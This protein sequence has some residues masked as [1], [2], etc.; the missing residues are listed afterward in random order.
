MKAIKAIPYIIIVIVM[1]LWS[2]P[3]VAQTDTVRNADPLAKRMVEKYFRYSGN[4]NTFGELYSTTAANK[5][6]PSST[7]R[8]MLNVTFTFWK[9]QVPIEL[10]VSTEEVSYR[11]SFNRLGFNPQWRFIRFRIGD[12]GGR[13]SDYTVN[14]ISIR[15][16]GVEIEPSWMRLFF[17]YGITQR[18]VDN[19]LAQNYAYERKLIA[20]KLGFGNKQNIYLDINVMKAVDDENSIQITPDSARINPMENLAASID[21]QLALFK[22]RFR[23]N[24]EVAASV[25]SL[26]KLAPK[27]DSSE[28]PSWARDI[29]P[30]RL[31]TRLD[32]AYRT[33]LQVSTKPFSLMTGYERIGAGYTSLGL[34]YSNND[35]V[36]YNGNA[37]LWIIP[38][39]WSIRGSFNY[40][41]DNLENTKVKT[42]K[43]QMINVST[44]VKPVRALTVN[45]G[46]NKNTLKNETN[47]DSLIYWENNLEKKRLLFDTFNDRY[48]ISGTYSYQLMGY[49]FS[50]MLSYSLQKS[51]KKNEEE[52]KNPFDAGI[53][54]IGQNV[55]FSTALSAGINATFSNNKVDTVSIKTNTFGFN[56]SYNP[57]KKMNNTL[58]VSMQKTGE[59]KAINYTLTMR[60]RL[61]SRSSLSM[62]LYRIEFID[63]ANPAR[64]Y[65]ENRGTLTLS[66]NF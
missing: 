10:V 4:F 17:Y 29:F 22:R 25:I 16:G 26:N 36:R 24:G 52:S 11:Q 43:H 12:F 46:Y 65:K 15:G 21:G 63:P 62:N 66:Y 58:A 57:F 6:R 49:N 37:N 53:V 55:M 60:Y 47:L 41:Y 42:L 27:A 48:Q 51:Q 28:I 31:S 13:L 44:M 3:L 2:V 32:F 23:V 54:T 50:S 30:V 9:F 45:F 8:S 35:R 18:A 5:R 56:L 7:A 14:G 34:P 64:E 33:T 61:I 20:G 1:I 38:S 19:P 40:S 39:V 59:Q